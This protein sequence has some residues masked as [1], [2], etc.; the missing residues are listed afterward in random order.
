MF[1]RYIRI[2]RAKASSKVSD[3]SDRPGVARALSS[4]DSQR[5]RI[6]PSFHVG[7]VIASMT[8]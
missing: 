3:Y 4:Y 8:G 2:D 1:D 6:V 5:V 7:E